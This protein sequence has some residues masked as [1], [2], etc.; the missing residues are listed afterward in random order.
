MLMIT[1]LLPKSLWDKLDSG[2]RLYRNLAKNLWN[3]L[4][5]TNMKI[6]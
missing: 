1:F 5:E 6:A 2:L 3:V 4:S